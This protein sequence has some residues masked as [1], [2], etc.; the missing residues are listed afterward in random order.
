MSNAPMS[1]TPASEEKTFL[2]ALFDFSFTQWVTL[3]IAGV[4]YL[5]AIILLTLFSVIGIITVI[6]S[7]TEGALVVVFIA[8]TAIV[9]FL[10]VLLIRLG[11]E[12]SIATIAVA[13][14]TASLRNQ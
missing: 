14:N 5:I 10:A 1:E 2:Q 7:G 12:A 11:I 9:W 13:Q 4:L 8:A 3:R 6:A